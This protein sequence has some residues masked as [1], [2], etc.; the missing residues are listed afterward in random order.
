M[1]ISKDILDKLGIDLTNMK[2]RESLSDLR[3]NSPGM[4]IAESKKDFSF[5]IN[6]GKHTLWKK[7]NKKILSLY[8]YSVL[9]KDKKNIIRIGPAKE[10]F[11]DIFKQYKGENLDNKKILIWRTGGL[12]DICFINPS[13]RWMKKKYPTCKI[14]FSCSPSYKHLIENW[15]C[16][17]EFVDFPVDCKY[18]YEC[19]YHATF[20]GV[21][22]RCKEAET[23]NAYKL[24]SEWLGLNIPDKDLVPEFST[25][26]VFD[27]FV[28]EYIKQNNLDEYIVVQ[29]R[30]STPIRTPS[31]NCWNNILLPLLK[32]GKKIVIT[33]SPRMYDRINAFIKLAIPEQYR[34]LVFNFSKYSADIKS[35][36]SLI[37]KAN[38][39]IAPDTS[40]IHIAQGVKC[41]VLGIY[42]AFPGEIRMGTYINADWVEPIESDICKF[43]GKH[44][45]THGQECDGLKNKKG[46]TAPCYGYLDYDEIYQK[47]CKLYKARR[48]NYERTESRIEPGEE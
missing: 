29:L 38:L 22:E 10:K 33:D 41:P 39:V 31:T 28:N 13:M 23:I 47:I 9:Q 2:T 21:I 7:G 5:S 32:D 18:L 4:V 34:Y 1:E 24:F 44:C 12:G 37:N 40:M 8:L 48:E 20:E 42:G 43:N 17:D 14:Y 30:T 6:Y 27:L 16:I 19:D 26:P 35:S 15:D 45:C 11:T 36:I 3:K 25:D 46:S